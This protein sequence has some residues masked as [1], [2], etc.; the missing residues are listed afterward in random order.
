MC[1]SGPRIKAILALA[2][3]TAYRVERVPQKTL[4]AMVADHRG[5][6]LLAEGSDREPAIGLDMFLDGLAEGAPSL[7]LILDH[8]SDPHNLGA[9]LRSADVFGAGLVI[10]PERRAA[11][12]SDTVARSS[13]GASAYV[14]LAVVPNLANA[15]RRLKEADFWVYAAEMGGESLSESRLPARLALVLGSEG[16]GVGRTLRAACD[17]SLGIPQG[18]HVDSLNVSVAAGLFMYEYRRQRGG[19]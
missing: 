5:I 14:P 2:E 4:D 10:I 16:S 1:G 3:K 12:E 8:V 15:A 6:L 18:G 17:G 11:G 9:V 7:V 19:R 13:A